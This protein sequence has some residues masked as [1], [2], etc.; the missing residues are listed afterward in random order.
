MAQKT[1]VTLV[2]DLDGTTADETVDFGID[3]ATY[4]IDLTSDHADALR[5]AL[6]DY[7]AKARRQGRAPRTRH[8]RSSTRTAV[9][10]SNGATPASADREQSKAVR[11]W[12][13]QHGYTVSD[14]GRIPSN[15]TEAYHR[16][17]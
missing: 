9:R 3:G 5:E 8:S 17:Q 2:D 14:R 11:A 15:I 6:A 16:A 7:V 10:A 12:A 13:R 4:E 1:T